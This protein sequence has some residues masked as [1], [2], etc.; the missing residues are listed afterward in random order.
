MFDIRRTEDG[1]IALTGRLDAASAPA[2]RDFLAALDAS[3]RLDFTGLD[4]IASVGL[5]ILAAAQKRL[6]ATGHALVLANL[7]PHVREVLSLAGFEGV[8]AFE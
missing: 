5:G 6:S 7:R 8:F 3:A 1:T 2:A 4:Y